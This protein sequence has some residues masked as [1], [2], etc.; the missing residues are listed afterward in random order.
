M[1]TFSGSVIPNKYQDFLILRHMCCI[2]NAPECCITMN[3]IIFYYYILGFI[4]NE[5]LC[6][7]NNYGE[8]KL[9][10]C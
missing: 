9:R 3:I 7:I 10:G 2:T 1:G 8:K 4:I 5:F 6:S